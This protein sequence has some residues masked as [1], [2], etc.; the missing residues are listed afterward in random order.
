MSEIITHDN[1]IAAAIATAIQ[2]P[3]VGIE[4]LNALWEIS[5]KIEAAKAHAAYHS[6]MAQFKQNAPEIVRNKAVSF[7]AGKTSYKHATLDAVAIPIAAAL[8]ACGLSH[9][10]YI[11]QSEAGISVTCVLTHV[12]GHSERVTLCAGA[13][14]SGSKNPIQ[15]VASTVTY[16]QRYTLLAI[17]G[18]AVQDEHDDDGASA[19]GAKAA[20]AADLA[21]QIKGEI[22][23][24][25][26]LSD[27]LSEDAKN[28]MRQRYNA[29]AALPPHKRLPALVALRRDIERQTL[30]H[31][32]ATP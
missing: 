21:A 10:W 7:G 26:T 20:E 22:A 23:K 3:A 13:D 5:R 18:L 9:A 28:D 19:G 2:N 31:A 30:P 27:D 6:A 25:R 29:A 17:T 11:G 1:P 4:Q 32:G 12:L 15:A 8:S 14:N 16:L 24:I